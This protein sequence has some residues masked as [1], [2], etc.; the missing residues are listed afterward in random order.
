MFFARQLAM[1]QFINTSSLG[2][3]QGAVNDSV[4]YFRGVPYAQPPIGDLRFRPPQPL[5][6]KHTRNEPLIVQ[7]FGASCLQETYIIHGR[8]EGLWPSINVT[9]ISEDCLFLNVYAPHP[10]EEVANQRY[11]VMVYFHAGEFR[12][13]SSNDQENNWPYFSR[14]VVLVT[15]NSRMGVFGYA[16][17]DLLRSRDRGGSG[18]SQGNSTGNYGIQDQ[19]MA[20]RWIQDNIVAFGGDSNNVLI[21]GESSGG[22]QV[23]VHVTNP[24]S[25]GLFHKVALESP[26]RSV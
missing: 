11:P 15:V 17:S 3:L 24:Q 20:L 8:E 14:N 12:G 13:G 25:W 7:E 9:P 19:R 6:K 26:G 10:S 22:T 23:G 2:F 4:Q 16:A 5:S 21:F 1:A 18:I